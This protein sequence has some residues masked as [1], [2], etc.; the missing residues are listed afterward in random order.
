MWLLPSGRELIRKVIFREVN[1]AKVTWGPAKQLLVAL[2][3]VE[4]VADLNPEHEELLRGFA[5]RGVELIRRRTLGRAGLGKIANAWLGGL[6]ATGPY[7]WEGV[8]PVLPKD[9]AGTAAY[10]MGHR[11][12]KLGRGKEPSGSSRRR[13]TA[14]TKD[15]QSGD[16]RGRNWSV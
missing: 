11:Y 5:D 7:G 1:Y 8:K 15:H 16:W 14:R 4:A 10:L 13:R 6:G 12:L 9:A 2:W 3:H